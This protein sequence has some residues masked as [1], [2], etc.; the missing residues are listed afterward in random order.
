MDVDTSLRLD[1]I[2]EIVSKYVRPVEVRLF[3]SRATGSADPD[4][5]FDLL[6]VVPDGPSRDELLTL[7]SRCRRELASHGI[8]AD[9]LIR[10]ESMVEDFRDKPGSL[11]RSALVEGVEI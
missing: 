1:R 4:S 5:D 7:S 9:I 11:I 6:V 2:R 8:D 10:T 3:G